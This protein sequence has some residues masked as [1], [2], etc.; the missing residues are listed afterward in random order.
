M[1]RW[2]RRT[3]VIIFTDLDG[4]LLDHHDYSFI[5]A[6]DALDK[7]RDAGIPLIM[8]SSKTRAEIEV[9][10][11]RL[12]NKDPF[13][14]EN[15]GAIFYPK[16]GLTPGSGDLMNRGGYNVQELGMFYPELLVRFKILKNSLGDRIRGFSEMDAREVAAS[17]GLSVQDAELAKNR[18][19]SEPF[20]FR[21]N[22]YE[23]QLLEERVKTLSLNL[24]QG[25]RF[26]HLLGDNNKGRA[27]RLL[28]GV[29]RSNFS[30]VKT[31]AVGDSANDYAMLQ[32]ADIPILVQKPGGGYDES[33]AGL[34][35][36]VR[37]PGVGP[38]GWNSALLDILGSLTY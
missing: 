22:K 10:R 35:N 27:I 31:V 34:S 38:K 18:E 26:F 33:A 17:T 9:W 24:T 1:Q 5:E 30:R 14:S 28:A 7:I 6:Q 37:G 4:T 2:T 11:K 20:I 13:I 25:G 21:G 19:Y 12:H 15:G 32:E 36:L 23:S 29:Y 16:G 8:C 3:Q